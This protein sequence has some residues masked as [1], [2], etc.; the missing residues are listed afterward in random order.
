MGPALDPAYLR[1]MEETLL[2]IGPGL[3][4]EVLGVFLAEVPPRLDGLVGAEDRTIRRAA[5][6]IRGAAASVGAARLARLCGEIDDAPDGADVRRLLPGIANEMARVVN[7]VREV[8]RDA[9]A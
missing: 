3:F 2:D 5:H 4:H 1:N 7:A 8:L 9:A 6:S